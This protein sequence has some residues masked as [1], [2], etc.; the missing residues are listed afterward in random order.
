L[1][2]SPIRR[3]P[4]KET[5][6]KSASM[7]WTRRFF[8]MECPCGSGGKS[9]GC[10]WRGNGC[11]EKTP[12]G[13]I[14]LSGI[15]DPP[16]RNNR[17][18]LST[19]G[20]CSSKM[21][22]EHFV[23]RNVLARLATNSLITFENAGHFFRGKERV[24]I[25]VD[26]FVAR[27][28]CDTHNGALG[29][30]DSAAGLAFSTIEALV[31]DITGIAAE[32]SVALESFHISSGL[33]IERWMIKVFCGLVAAGKIR[34]SSGQTLRL[35][36]LP[37]CLQDALLGNT[38]L[39]SPLGLYQNTFVGQTLNLGGLSFGTIKLTDGSD[40]VGG[41]L[42]SL[43]PMNF[44]LITSMAYGQAFSE[45]NWYRHQTLAWNVKQGSSRLSYLL[46]Y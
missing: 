36:D 40:A 19:F 20:G 13:A 3:A 21:T 41:L 14:S 1:R 33:D 23:S 25:G 11:W 28:L 27:V 38:L 32:K 15:K 35:S 46:T 16:S 12:I 7:P 26:D 42:L 39:P 9:Y 6:L 30:L 22:R 43:G 37:S 24:E 8:N 18:Y 45:P 2:I 4:P 31:K 44:V 10:C 17:C 34:A 29:P 5:E